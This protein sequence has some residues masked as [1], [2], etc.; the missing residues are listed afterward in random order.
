MR[1][2]ILI[3]G[4]LRTLANTFKN[5]KQNLIDPNNAD[6]FVYADVKLPRDHHLLWNHATL[7]DFYKSIWG[8][9]VKRAITLTEKDRAEYNAILNFLWD[10]KPGITQEV[11]GKTGVNR[12]YLRRSGSIIEYFLLMKAGHIMTAYEKEHNFKYDVVIRS[13]NDIILPE[14]SNF[15]PF[16][17]KI[18][19]NPNQYH[20]SLFYQQMELEQLKRV[21]TEP[22]PETDKINLHAMNFVNVFRD[23]LFWVAPR[24]A[25]LILFNLIYHYGDYID[26]TDLYSWNAEGQ[27]R[28]ILKHHNIAFLNFHSDIQEQYMS[29]RAY[30]LTVLDELDNIDQRVDKDLFLTIYR[31]PE[32][33]LFS[34]DKDCTYDEA[35]VRYM[36]TKL[37]YNWRQI[38]EL[39]PT[40]TFP[41]YYLA[42]DANNNKKYEE[43]WQ[44]ELEGLEL[45]ANKY[46]TVVEKYLIYDVMSVT[47]YYVGQ[48]N[49]GSRLIFYLMYN[50]HV[51]INNKNLAKQNLLY[52][53]K[54]IV[55]HEFLNLNPQ[56]THHKYSDKL[57]CLNPAIIKHDDKIYVNCRMN[58]WSYWPD[59]ITDIRDENGIYRAHN[60]LMELDNNYQPQSANLLRLTGIKRHK[61]EYRGLED[62]RLLSHNDRLY[63]ISSSQQYSNNQLNQMVLSEIVGNKIVSVVPLIGYSEQKPQKNWLAW[64]NHHNILTVVYS[65]QPFIILEVDMESGQCR[66]I[67]RENVFKRLSLSDIHGSCPPVKVDDTYILIF[68]SK[69]WANGKLIIIHYFVEMDFDYILRKIS[70]PFYF[71]K[72]GVE[73]ATQM[74]LDGDNLIIGLGI[75]DK[76]SILTKV[77]IADLELIALDEY[78]NP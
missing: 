7:I 55:H 60:C 62:S 1:V 57:D 21:I 3:T 43:A 24:S 50:P 71:N 49:L 5:I 58:N 10:Y 8:D 28:L 2:A 69:Y 31:G 18:I 26:P 14:I 72:I 48:W 16:Y 46:E 29:S 34:N 35:Q 66:E 42:L 47:A 4:E 75:D 44:L 32:Y 64:I 56:V 25:A 61:T 22:N 13:R 54:P 23:N 38:K 41:H 39:L 20:D 52:Y 76:Q 9:N 17:E 63:I 36:T 73:F 59:A 19:A 40:N 68:H 37:K 27:F 77:N 51:P 30:N 11:V 70:R 74:I 53:L 45:I 78:F 15:Q 67:V 33:T 6:V 65:F 12:E